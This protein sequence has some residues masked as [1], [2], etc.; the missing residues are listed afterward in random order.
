MVDLKH[1]LLMNKLF[2]VFCTF[3]S[4]TF[5]CVAQEPDYK[6]GSYVNPDFKRK[7]LDISFNSVGNFYKTTDSKNNT[8]NGD[9]GLRYSSISNSEK[10]Q[11]YTYAYLSGIAGSQSGE[12]DKL[13]NASTMLN[14]SREA[15]HFFKSK[16]FIE[17][18]PNIIVTYRYDQEN[19][20][21]Y[22][23]GTVDG[24]RV[25][26]EYNSK[27]NYFSSNIRLK[28]GI[29]KGRIEDVRDARQAMFVLQEL[30]KKNL[31]KRTLTND[32]VNALTEQIT[33]IKNQRYYDYRVQ[34]IDEI[35][36]V[37]SFLVA[38]NFVD[39]ENSVLYYTSLYDKWMYG[40]RDMR[41]AGSYIKGGISPEYEFTDNRGGFSFL[42]DLSLETYKYLNISSYYGAALY[43]DYS[44]E[45]PLSLAWQSSFNAGVSSG[46]YK[47]RRIDDNFYKTR[48]KLNYTLGYY[49]NTRTYISGG[50]SCSYDWDRNSYRSNNYSDY[51]KREFIRYFYSDLNIKGYYF[52]SPQ[53]RLFGECRFYY[54]D[55]NSARNVYRTNYP[56]TSFQLGIT[57][58]VF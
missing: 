20:D 22:Y 55:Q 48:I 50:I 10:D 56:A 1:L 42:S 4:Y 47:H 36:R 19:D 11:A 39:K 29:G 35:S 9:L 51:E 16:T 46:L 54:F 23:N 7:E 27:S 14:I 13:R 6:L 44:N 40:D 21:N 15:F 25:M 28:L 12:S 34:L 33:L 43:V 57:Y 38:N 53:L 3:I 2:I 45:K 41:K 24:T 5:F 37:D 26:G 32:E 18:S 58:A 52:L 49:P 30:Q 8:I 17:L 31:L